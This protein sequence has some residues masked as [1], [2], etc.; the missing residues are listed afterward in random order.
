V[1]CAFSKEMLALYVGD[2]LVDGDARLTERHLDTCA[3][4]R[5]FVDGL[6]ASQSRLRSLRLETADEAACAGMRRAVMAAIGGGTQRVS[7]WLRVERALLGH[8]AYALAACAIVS[9]VSVSVY[10]QMR[11]SSPVPATVAAVFDGRNILERPQGYANWVVAGT[12]ANGKHSHGKV[13]IDPT[14]YREYSATGRFPQG[15]VMVW[16][17]ATPP[18]TAAVAAAP[19]LLVSVKDGA[20]FDGGW[21]FYDFT[22]TNGAA[23]ATAPEAADANCRTCHRAD[24]ETDHVFTQAY[25]SLRAGR[26]STH[27]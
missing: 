10:A 24:A 19:Q 20:R 13:F 17:R 21:G 18:A 25:P 8:P 22:A 3:D 4:C 6:R 15:T 12:T 2:D 7:W 27:T 9:F 23:K 1:S 5:G 11:V 14:A 16:E 26:R